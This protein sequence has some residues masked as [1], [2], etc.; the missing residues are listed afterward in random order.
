LQINVSFIFTTGQFF[1]TNIPS[2][3]FEINII[4]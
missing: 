3:T 2:N 1:V 4:K